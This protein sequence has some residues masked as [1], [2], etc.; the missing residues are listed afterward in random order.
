MGNIES[1]CFHLYLLFLSSLCLRSKRLF[2][3]PYHSPCRALSTATSVFF[4]VIFLYLRVI[5]QVSNKRVPSEKRLATSLKAFLGFLVVV[6]GHPTHGPFY[7]LQGLLKALPRFEWNPASGLKISVY[8]AMLPVLAAQEQRAL[9]YTIR[10]RA[11]K[12]GCDG[13][14]LLLFLSSFYSFASNRY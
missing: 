12:E 14:L 7:L 3:S 9:P 8:V 2:C 1:A 11:G 10:V 5:K 6:P 13:L 4:K